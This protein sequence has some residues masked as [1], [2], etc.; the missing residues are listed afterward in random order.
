MS[1]LRKASLTAHVAISV[2]WLGSVAAFLALAVSGLAAS[3]AHRQN[4]AYLSMETV[5]LYVIVPLAFASLASGLL[6]GLLSPWGIL[7]HYW[8]VAKLLLT[9]VATGLLVLHLGPIHALA[10]AAHAGSVAGRRGLQVQLL[11]D[12]A[13][14]IVALLLATLLS[15]VKPRGVTPLGR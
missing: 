8:V 12:A 10:D 13:L 6:Q 1:A 15:V 9:V 2:G 11:F 4:A 14:A 7:K 5:T 3:D